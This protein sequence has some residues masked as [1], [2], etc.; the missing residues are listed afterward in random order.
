MQFYS[1]RID[2]RPSVEVAIVVTVGRRRA[3]VHLS[4]G[5]EVKRRSTHRTQTILSF[6]GLPPR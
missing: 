1:L 3:N 6:V 5:L 4:T 2:H